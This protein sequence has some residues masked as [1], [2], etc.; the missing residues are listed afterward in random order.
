VAKSS[1]RFT[2]FPTN[3]RI[4]WVTPVSPKERD[5]DRKDKQNGLSGVTLVIKNALQWWDGPAR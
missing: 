1:A 2:I 5:I 3:V 4:E